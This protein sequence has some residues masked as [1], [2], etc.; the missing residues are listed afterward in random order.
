[1]MRS[2]L[3]KIKGSAKLKGYM[4]I[5]PGTMIQ[6]EGVGER[7]N[8]SIFVTGVDHKYEGRWSTNIHFGLR[9]ERYA[10]SHTDGNDPRAA[11][12]VGAVNGL[13]IGIVVQLQNDPEGQDRILVIIP[14]VNKNSQGIWARVAC[15]DAGNQRGAF[16]LPEIGDE[17]IIGFIN[18]DPRD[19]VVLG[20]LHSSS[21]PA[22]VIAQDVNHEKGFT[23][24]SKMRIKFNDDT[25]TIIIDTP[26]GNSIML[27]EQEKKIELKD[28]NSNTIKMDTSG[29]TLESPMNINIKAGRNLS[30]SAAASAIVDGLSLSLKANGDVSIEGAVAKLASSGTMVINGSLVKIN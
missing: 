3:S 27:D 20:M 25:K 19:A 7:F 11:G 26:A 8:G 24:R 15:L 22:P 21:K 6:L 23:T 17:V 18:D 4:E 29:L 14:V 16:F 13:Q 2:R 10:E 5:K 28:Q 12:L 30:L 1:M 9:A